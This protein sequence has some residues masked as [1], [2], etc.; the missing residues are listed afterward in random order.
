MW[1]EDW[2]SLNYHGGR[3]ETIVAVACSI[4]HLKLV[5]T[6]VPM[7]YCRPARSTGEDARCTLYM[8][9]NAQSADDCRPYTSITK[10]QLTLLNLKSTLRLVSDREK[11]GA[12][13]RS[14]KL[15]WYYGRK[16]PHVAFE[17]ETTS[18][19]SRSSLVQST[20]Q[21]KEQCVLSERVKRGM[22]NLWDSGCLGPIAKESSLRRDPFYSLL[23]CGLK[24]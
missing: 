2:S 19:G 1:D 4:P 3:V 5:W 22:S 13:S 18:V 24:S 23:Q 17:Y 16:K 7:A 8:N 14:R 15:E 10:G 11:I 21:A 6:P 9:N 12:V 20:K